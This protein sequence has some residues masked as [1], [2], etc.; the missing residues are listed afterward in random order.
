MDGILYILAVLNI[1]KGFH[2]EIHDVINRLSRQ[3]QKPEEVEDYWPR[4][5]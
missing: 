1:H 2:T 5:N 3:I 4:E